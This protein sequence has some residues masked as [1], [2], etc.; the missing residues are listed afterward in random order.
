MSGFIL[1]DMSQEFRIPFVHIVL[2][3]DRRIAL[4]MER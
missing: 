3:K 4:E 2:F 1:L